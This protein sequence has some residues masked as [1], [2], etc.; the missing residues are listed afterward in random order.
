MNDSQMTPALDPYL[1]VD[2]VAARLKVSRWKVYELIR[3][4]ELESFSVSRCRR[5]PATAVTE[6]VDRLR[7]DVA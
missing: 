4:H 5:I 6:L 3:T 2:E 7:R 1:T